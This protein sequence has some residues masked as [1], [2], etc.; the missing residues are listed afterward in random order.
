MATWAVN[1]REKERSGASYSPAIF[2]RD[3]DHSIGGLK[4]HTDYEVIITV[5][6][7]NKVLMWDG[8]E[9]VNSGERGEIRISVSGLGYSIKRQDDG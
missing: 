4:K 9:I 1:Y 3:G 6:R 7:N 8:A 2:K 5:N